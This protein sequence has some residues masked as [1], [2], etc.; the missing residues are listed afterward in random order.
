MGQSAL[1]VQP[2]PVQA[3]THAQHSQHSSQ[4]GRSVT[5]RTHLHASTS[6][7][8]ALLLLQARPDFVR[9][10]ASR[11]R[12]G[13]GRGG[14]AQLACHHQAHHRAARGAGVFWVGPTPCRQ[15]V[16]HIHH[17]VRR[18]HLAVQCSAAC[19]QC[20]A[21]HH[22]KQCSVCTMQSTMSCRA[23]CCAEHHDEHCV[24]HHTVRPARRQLRAQAR[25]HGIVNGP[26]CCACTYV[27]DAKQ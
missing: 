26:W 10:G 14:R 6:P 22:A 20:R 16:L 8:V 23:T 11:I 13:H 5:R 1:R 17:A 15:P 3:Q 27:C 9:G 19:A 21:I 12:R 24:H 25:V 2:Q 7:R 18:E 4:T